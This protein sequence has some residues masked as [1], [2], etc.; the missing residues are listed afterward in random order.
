MTCAPVRPGKMPGM[1][2]HQIA[3][4]MAAGRLV[5]GI[6]LLLFPRRIGRVWIGPVADHREASVMTRGMGAR[7][8]ALAAG[9]LRALANGEPARPWIV[10]GIASDSTDALATLAAAGQIG[11]LRAVIV[12]ASAFSAA[13]TGATIVDKVDAA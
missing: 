3:R 7:D 4:M 10:G 6:L 12:A 2:H 1:D 8:A 11:R 13:V 9:T 5:L